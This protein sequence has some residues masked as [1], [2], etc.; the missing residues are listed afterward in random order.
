MFIIKLMKAIKQTYFVNSSLSEAWKALVDSEHI[1]AWDEG[2][3]KMNDKVG[4]KF[5][6]LGRRYLRKKRQAH[7]FEK[8]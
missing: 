7:T 1:N 8:K 4:T 2:P 5:E 3:A 6:F